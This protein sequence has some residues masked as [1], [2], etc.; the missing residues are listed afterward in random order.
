MPSSFLCFFIVL[1]L[2]LTLPLASLT[3]CPV[4][5]LTSMQIFVVSARAGKADASNSNVTVKIPIKTEFFMSCPYSSGKSGCGGAFLPP[6]PVV[7]AG[8]VDTV[9]QVTEGDATDAPK[10]LGGPN[11]EIGAEPNVDGPVANPALGVVALPL[12]TPKFVDCT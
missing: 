7:T 4:R 1:Q 6:H 9:G 3:V 2:C 8:A 5:S 10:L 12:G 11:P